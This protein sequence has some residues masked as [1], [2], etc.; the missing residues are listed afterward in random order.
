[1]DRVRGEALVAILDELDARD[2]TL[3]AML[4]E[5]AA[6]T[7]DVQALRARASETVA[8]LDGLP[9][10]RASATAEL[11]V[12][13]AVLLES[14][15]A[16]AVAQGALD[17]LERGRKPQADQLDRARKEL[18]Q[19]VADE[20]DA[21]A[22][23]DRAAARLAD[24]DELELALGAIGEGLVVTARA[25]TV[26]LRVAPRVA[27]AGRGE[28]G[29]GVRDLDEWGARAR[30]A[31]FVSHSTLAT[32]RER[33]LHEANVLGASVFGDAGALSVALVRQ[34]VAELLV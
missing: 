3:A 22:R 31:L 9:A 16:T 1:V 32:E 14:A 15:K 21:T 23:R 34:R 24:L 25:L 2:R 28:P 7:D 17:E 30:A 20:H 6:L 29:P 27:D 19:A 5:L 13:H 26:R 12:A 11:E 33:V 8:G 10:D 4:A 18:E